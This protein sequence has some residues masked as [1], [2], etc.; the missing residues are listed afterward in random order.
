MDDSQGLYPPLDPLN[1][2]IS[3]FRPPPFFTVSTYSIDPLFRVNLDRNP[4][5]KSLLSRP[6]SSSQGL[7]SLVMHLGGPFLR[8]SISRF[9]LL[10]WIPSWLKRR[11][12]RKPFCRW[13]GIRPSHKTL[14]YHFFPSFY[15]RLAGLPAAILPGCCS[16]AAR[17]T[18][19]FFLV[20]LCAEKWT[21]A[22]A[23]NLHLSGV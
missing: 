10:G 14:L 20:H 21:Y 7:E 2:G 18:N 1:D 5:F 17:K 13:E 4:T 22:W 12:P 23:R 8:S 19:S 6:F 11:L 9:S 3:F 15:E 16:W